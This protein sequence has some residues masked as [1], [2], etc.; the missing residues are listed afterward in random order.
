MIAALVRKLAEPKV[1]GIEGLV[2]KH[3]HEEVVI[4]HH[5][6]VIESDDHV[7]V[8]VV[9]KKII[10]KVERLFQVAVGFV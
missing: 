9:N 1:V 10:P 6:T 8:F 2:T 5:D 3:V 4:A 7:I